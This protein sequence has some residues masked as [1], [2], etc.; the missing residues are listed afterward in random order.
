[1]FT[2]DYSIVQLSKRRWVVARTN[3]GT[4]HKINA[5]VCTGG[6]A[7]GMVEGPIE[8]ELITIPLPYLETMKI[9][10]VIRE[11]NIWAARER[12]PDCFMDEV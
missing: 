11:F 1:M 5:D 12:W 8:F 3:K 9:A 10:I 2:Y 4:S 7:K 6:I